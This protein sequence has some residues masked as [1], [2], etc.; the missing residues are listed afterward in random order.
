MSSEILLKA[1]GLKKVFL[2]TKRPG[3]LLWY[4]LTGRFASA[5]DQHSVLRNVDLEVRRGET[6]GIMGRNGAGKSTLLGML[7]GLIPPTAGSVERYGKIATLLGVGGTFS[8][9][10][11][12]RQNALA[13]CAMQG[14]SRASALERLESIE[15]FA[16]IGEYFDLPVRTYSSGMQARVA[17]AA[18]I[19]VEADL[20]IVDETLAVGDAAFKMKCYDRI[21]EMKRD[22]QTFLLVSHNPNLVAN[23]CTRAIVIEGGA[24][25]YDGDTTGA[26]ECY[27]KIRFESA[28]KSPVRN[29]KRGG[30]STDGHASFVDCHY[31]YSSSDK[32]AEHRLKFGI[33]PKRDVHGLSFNLGIRNHHGIVVFSYNSSE[34]NKVIPLAVAEQVIHVAVNFSDCLL[35]GRYFLSLSTSENIGDEKLPVA[36]AQ[37]ILSF[38]IARN[39]PLGGIVDPGLKIELNEELPHEQP[40]Q[41][42]DTF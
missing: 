38:D 4:A 12:G 28:S 32:G 8:P 24:K 27:K 11:T 37:N 34:D 16:D 18:A 6:V 40:S 41:T 30:E 39:T 31:A 1:S 26:L 36:L 15:A 10:L 33:L 13:F 7:G 14:I 29:V 42:M 35:P 23:F 22:G 25:V 17:F 9:N 2:G 20:I 5:V 3:A 19:H 21:E